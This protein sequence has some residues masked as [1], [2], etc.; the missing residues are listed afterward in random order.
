MN[1][2][3]SGRILQIFKMHRINLFA[4]DSSTSAFLE[5]ENIVGQS[6]SRKRHAKE[7]ETIKC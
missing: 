3:T 6:S 7:E 1:F 4:L 5:Y 2:K